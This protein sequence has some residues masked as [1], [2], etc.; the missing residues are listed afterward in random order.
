MKKYLLL[1]LFISFEII[2]AQSKVIVYAG[3]G[4]AG[5]K[6]GKVK[7]AMFNVPFG[8]CIDNESNLYIADIGNN[9]IRKIDN[10]GIVSTFAGSVD[11][12]YVDGAKEEAL[13]YQPTGICTDNEG[14][15]Y[16]ADFLNH[17]IRKIDDEGNVT[18]IAGNGETGFKDGTGNEAH[19]NYPRGIVID[20]KG[21]L[22]VG[23]SW[24]HRIRKITPAGVVSTFAGY[25]D[26]IGTESRGT[27][28]DGKGADAR[29]GTPCGLAIDKNDNIY[30]ADALNHAA[31][32]IDTQGNVTTIAGNGTIGSD[33]GIGQSA[34][35][36]TPT[37]LFVTSDGIVYISDTYN[38]KIRKVA[39]DG[40][41]TTIAHE[42]DGIDYPRGIVYDENSG[43]IYF[44]D[45]N[46]NCIKSIT[47][48]AE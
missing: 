10:A 46:H 19:F 15:F 5:Y 35:L 9:C 25:A 32:K 38:S 3:N 6:D 37:E 27:L 16:V 44:V 7:D 14:N 40:T 29:F 41:V 20:S 18:T 17:Y 13:F 26:E 43:S 48:Q 8:M 36:N 23:D 22:Y 1:A 28:K 12:G 42:T 21:N 11:S 4:E 45:F 47:T 31:R 34:L 33:D 39:A 30:V 24:N 2:T